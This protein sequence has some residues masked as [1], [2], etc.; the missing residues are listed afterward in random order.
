MPGAFPHCSRP[1]KVSHSFGVRRAQSHLASCPPCSIAD[2]RTGV[3]Q[4]PSTGFPARERSW[5]CSMLLETSFLRETLPEKGAS[6]SQRCSEQGMFWDLLLGV[7]GPL[8]KALV[9]GQAP[10][11]PDLLLWI[12]H[13]R[14]IKARGDA[15]SLPCL[16]VL[17][18][19]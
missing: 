2:Q 7:Q 9:C 5:E 4:K 1:S 8:W 16:S 12:L 3:P 18:A 14:R 15:T 6:N 19:L 13:A 11:F 10:G 17:S